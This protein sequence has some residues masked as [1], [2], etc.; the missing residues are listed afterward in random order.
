MATEISDTLK[1][2]YN[3]TMLR[4]GR[5][6]DNK[7][8]RYWTK[9]IEEQTKTL[10]DFQD[11]L[12]RSPEYK[13]D[14]MLAFRDA[15][16]DMVGVADYKECFDKFVAEKGE[17]SLITIYDIQ[18][19]ITT[20]D[21]FVE[22]YSNVIKDM[23]K[24]V[25]G[26]EPDLGSLT[27]YLQKFQQV[28]PHSSGISYSVD[29][30]KN[31]LTRRQCS[32]QESFMPVSTPDG[33]CKDKAMLE[34]AEWDVNDIGGGENVGVASGVNEGDTWKA[35]ML[36]VPHVLKYVDT[37][38]Q[39]FK[40]NIHIREF[41]KYFPRL[42]SSPV[43]QCEVNVK[44]LYD[45]QMSVYVSATDVVMAYLQKTLDEET[46]IKAYLF[47]ID[48]PDFLETFKKDVIDSEEYAIMMK[49]KIMGVYSGLF[50]ED[51]SA[52]DIDYV[53]QKVKQQNCEL[54]DESI[55]TIVVD[56]KTETDEIMQHIYAVYMNVYEREPDKYETETYLEMYRKL[57]PE[58]S[59]DKIDDSLSDTLTLNLE[60]H[61]VIKNKIKR[62]YQSV[63]NAI[64]LPS[65]MYKLLNA[66]LG[67]HDKKDID[68]HIESMVLSVE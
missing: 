33:H 63:K 47:D 60:Y 65:I 45:Y 64:I 56:F 11:F 61:D 53:F 59:L 7:T 44:A 16:Y 24:L 49:K 42:L 46:F 37:F 58:N 27:K 13:N 40:R 2:R 66:V 48:K 32:E 30:L 20:S 25:M 52:E 31:D 26:E 22:K 36:N 54:G 28:T 50:M 62:A 4:K 18:K 35:Q 51:L 1:E 15:F 9:A 55:N 19:Y 67:M 8:L 3:T 21:V 14:I 12:V 38:E 41:L 39:V 43:E 10:D 68:K 6:I 23:H 57:L 17:D 5:N 29:D 34:H